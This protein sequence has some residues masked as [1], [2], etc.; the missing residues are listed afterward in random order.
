MREILF[1]AKSK[2]SNETVEGDLVRKNGET[3]ICMNGA[4][5]PVYPETVGEFTGITNMYGQKIFE[6]DIVK[7]VYGNGEVSFSKG[8]FYVFVKDWGVPSVDR[9]MKVLGNIYDNPELLI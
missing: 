8:E 2:I 6:K 5:V 4:Y 9:Y 7:T 1:K 3:Y